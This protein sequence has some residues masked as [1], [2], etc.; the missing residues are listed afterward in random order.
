[1]LTLLRFS[2]K[3]KERTIR[4][5]FTGALFCGMLLMSAQVDHG[6]ARLG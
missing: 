6:K 4:G 2:D 5:T 3:L 1:M